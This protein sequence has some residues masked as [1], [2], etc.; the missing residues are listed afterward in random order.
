MATVAPAS[1]E[2]LLPALIGVGALCP[3]QMLETVATPPWL[4]GKVT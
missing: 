3:V 2:T 4:A 1:T